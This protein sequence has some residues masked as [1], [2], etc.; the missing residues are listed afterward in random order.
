[1]KNP[2]KVGIIFKTR[3]LIEGLWKGYLLGFRHLSLKNLSV[4]ILLSTYTYRGAQIVRA[5]FI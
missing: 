5:T 3:L 1:M 4:F 2:T